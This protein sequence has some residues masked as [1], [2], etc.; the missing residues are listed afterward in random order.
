MNIKFSPYTR[1]EENIYVDDIHVGVIWKSG[2][3]LQV[4]SWYVGFNDGRQW[5]PYISQ[6]NAKSDCIMYMEEVGN[7]SS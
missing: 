3:P 6:P 7:G 4:S 5:G 2:N 1:G